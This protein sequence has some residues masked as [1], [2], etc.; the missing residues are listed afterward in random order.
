MY[1]TCQAHLRYPSLNTHFY[2]DTMFSS[3][4]KSLHG[5]NK[6]AQVFTNGAGC[7]LFYPMRKKS[8]A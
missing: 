1:K 8:K 6:C 4:S 5:N 2:T 3:T 7:V